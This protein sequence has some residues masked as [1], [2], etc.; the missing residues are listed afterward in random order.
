MWKRNLNIDIGLYNQE[1]KVQSD[2]LRQGD[3]SIARYAWVGDYLDPS[4]F[5]ELMTSSS[6]KNQT[7]WSNAAHDGLVE[8]ARHAADTTE[9][10]DLFRQAGD[11]LIADC[12]SLRSISTPKTTSST[13]W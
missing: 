13:P 8:A 6:G 3:Y 1:A 12:P 4:T 2:S 9:R 10:Y 11:L 5:L 7:G